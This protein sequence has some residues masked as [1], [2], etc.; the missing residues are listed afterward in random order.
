MIYDPLPDVLEREREREK[1]KKLLVYCCFF[2]YKNPDTKFDE[3]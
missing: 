3:Y 2:K 1:D